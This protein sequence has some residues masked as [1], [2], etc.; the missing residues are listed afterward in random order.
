MNA[1]L[2][3]RTTNPALMSQII[4]NPTNDSLSRFLQT[5]GLVFLGVIAITLGAKINF[6]SLGPIPIVMSDFAILVIAALFGRK[7]GTLTVTVYFLIGLAGLPVFANT[8]AEGFGLPYIL[9]PTGGYLLGFI[10]AAFYLGGQIERTTQFTLSTIFLKLIIANT[11]IYAIGI[12]G[13]LSHV[14]HSLASAVALG[15][16]PFLFMDLIKT[17]LATLLIQSTYKRV[18]FN[19]TQVAANEA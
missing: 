13:L 14:H 1:T 4:N 2:K 18:A 17:I 7:L 9:S 15:V 10:F 6:P 12:I 8:P 5:A 19:F 11:I 16:T 3:D